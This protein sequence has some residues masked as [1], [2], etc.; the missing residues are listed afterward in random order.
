[1]KVGQI[2]RNSIPAILEYCET[3]DRAE[4]AHLQDPR[5]SKQTFDINY[6]FCKPVE[7]I[8]E[9]ERVRY[10]TREHVVCGAAVRVTSQWFNPPTSN[11]LQLL[12][13]YLEQRKIEVPL[14]PNAPTEIETT[15]GFP[16]AARGR[17]KGNAIGN[18]QN[19][20]VRNIL[21]RLGEEQFNE[22]D[23]Q[24]VVHEFGNACAYCGAQT[25]LVM[26]HVIPINKQS[27]GE[28]RLGNLV[29]SCRTC[30]A[31]KGQ[32]DFRDFLSKDQGRIDAIQAHMAKY[33]YDPIGEDVQL[34]EIIDLA[35]EEVRNLADRYVA[36]ITVMQDRQ[37]ST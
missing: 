3:Q 23:W 32:H 33:S 9:T 27:L 34:I 10:W 26:D 22:A 4:I 37:R 35:H 5:Y 30:N 20:L 17:F 16:R 19:A 13:Q 36:I 12:N 25:D 15:A 8:G 6:P 2:V 21:S 31:K 28:H 1:M 18:A 14:L 11:S 24:E 7:A 29:P